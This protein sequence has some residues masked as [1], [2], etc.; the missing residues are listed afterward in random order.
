MAQEKSLEQVL[1]EYFAPAETKKPKGEAEY[2]IVVNGKTIPTRIKNKADLDKTLKSIA[3]EDAR[4]GTSTTV[5]IYKLEGKAT[6]TF[7]SNISVT[8]NEEETT[9]EEA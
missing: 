8:G 6:V 2:V 5:V 9:N 1:K 3:L 7:E 4:K